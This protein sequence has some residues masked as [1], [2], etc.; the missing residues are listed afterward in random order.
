MVLINIVDKEM[1]Q[2]PKQGK[3]KGKGNVVDDA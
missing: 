3:K 2:L 1:K